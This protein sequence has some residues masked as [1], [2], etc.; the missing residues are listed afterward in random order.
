MARAPS[1]PLCIDLDGTLILSDVTWITLRLFLKRYPLKIF[2][3]LFW[4]IQGRARLKYQLSKHISLDPKT[5]TY[6]QKLIEYIRSYTGTEII[7][8]TAADRHIADAVARHLRIFTDVM[9]SDG[10]TNLRAQAKADALIHR[11]GEKNFIYAGNSK[12]DLQVWKHAAV[13]IPINTNYC[14]DRKLER[15]KVKILHID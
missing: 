8:V 15:L 3:L 13:A 6:N 1:L 12:D 5:L 10:Y 14:V 7:L 11:F 4:F 2:S 9:A